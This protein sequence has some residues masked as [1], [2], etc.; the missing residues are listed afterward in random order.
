MKDGDLSSYLA[1]RDRMKSGDCILW[2][3]KSAL[4]WL[5]RFWSRG[6]NHASILL[7]LS[8][9]K[10]LKDRR[11]ML[12]ALEHGTVLTLLSVRLKGFRGEV[13]W[14]PVRADYDQYRDAVAAWALDYV[15]T[16]YD[17]DSLFRQAFAA[18]SAD[19]GKLFCSEYFYLAWKSAM[20][21]DFGMRSAPKPG[22]I[23]TMGIFD[24]PVK[25]YG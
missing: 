12:E 24:A 16:A 21:R 2:K 14:H 25:I 23:P 13:W 1:V 6:Y 18:V 20:N 7:N 10:V 8:E 5:I 19:A 22:D 9:Y 4:G 15:G 3:S 11:W 17:Y